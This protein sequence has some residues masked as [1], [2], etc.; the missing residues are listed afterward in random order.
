MLQI[1]SNGVNAQCPSVIG[2]PSP[3]HHRA[4]RIGSAIVGRMSRLEGLS[5]IVTVSRGGRPAGTMT[6]GGCTADTR[7]QIASVT[8][9]LT[10]TLAMMLVEAGVLDLHAPIGRLLDEAPPSWRD[11]TLHHL[12]S[13]G[14]GLGHWDAVPGLDPAVPATR[15]E[16]LS[17]TLRAPLSFAPGTRFHYSSP[18]FLIAGMVIERAA[19]TPFPELLAKKVL[20]PLGMTATVGGAHVPDVIGGRRGD[21][22]IAAWD[23]TSMVGAGDLVSTARDLAAYA[24]A[25]EAGALVTR[26]SLEWMRTAHSTLPTPDRGLDG[27]LEVVGYGYGTFVGTLDGLPAALHTGDNPGYAALLGW[28]GDDTTIVGLSNEEL[29]AWDEVIGRALVLRP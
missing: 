13:N 2:L 9:N 4:I 28:V 19:D 7:F 23:V 6:G 12:L 10:A 25:L 18:G 15:D 8:K 11:V 3:Y 27:R 17:R 5:G 24:H 22:P 20:R 16:R 26:S 29:T 21:D 14:S 1:V